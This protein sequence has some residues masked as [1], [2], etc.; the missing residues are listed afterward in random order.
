MKTL[1]TVRIEFSNYYL[2][3]ASGEKE[4][5]GTGARDYSRGPPPHTES[6]QEGIILKLGHFSRNAEREVC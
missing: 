2:L 3:L 6:R 5:P 1:Y 4:K